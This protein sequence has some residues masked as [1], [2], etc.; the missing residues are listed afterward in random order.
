MFKF[1]RF[2]ITVFI[3]ALLASCANENTDNLLLDAEGGVSNSSD[4]NE[5]NEIEIIDNTA[6]KIDIDEVELT[7]EQKLVSELI[8]VGD[9]VFFGYDESTI[10]KES[11]E[12][13]NKQHQ[14]LSRNPTLSI[15][16]EGHCDERGTREYNLALGERRASAVKN[17]LV[18]LGIDSNRIT[19]ISYGKEKPTVEGHN[20]W[21][22]TQNRTAI[23]F[24]NNW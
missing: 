14:F 19:V 18:S 2:V 22:W 23:T 21:A 24:I 9:R 11:A 8:E 13:L 16:I 3:F 6:Q 20:D 15:T 7:V 17:Y 1:L 5:D 12:T 10:S 4:N